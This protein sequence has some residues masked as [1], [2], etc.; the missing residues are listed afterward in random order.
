M[1]IY[2]IIFF[3]FGLYGLFGKV[4]Q[5]EKKKKMYLFITFGIMTLISSLRDENVGIDLGEIYKPIFYEI[6]KHN[7]SELGRINIEFGYAV[8]NKILLIFTK[9]FQIYT[10]ITSIFINYTYARFIYK[11]SKDVAISTSLYLLLDVLYNAIFV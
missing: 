7:W 2:I 4:N 9:N 8:F 1:Y 10:L 11:N 6:S 5:N 3:C